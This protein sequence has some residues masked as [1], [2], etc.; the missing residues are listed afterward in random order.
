LADISGPELRLSIDLTKVPE[1]NSW[2]V[3][4]VDSDGHS[5]RP[6]PAVGNAQPNSTQRTGSVD[7]RTH[8]V[9]AS[10]S[11]QVSI[12]GLHVA[13][14]Y[15]RLWPRVLDWWMFGAIGL[16]VICAFAVMVEV[17][18]L[19]TLRIEARYR[20]LLGTSLFSVSLCLMSYAI[21]WGA[22]NKF[23]LFFEGDHLLE[24]I[25]VPIGLFTLSFLAEIGSWAAV[26]VA[27]AT[28]AAFFFGLNV[29]MSLTPLAW[30]P[31]M[32]GIVVVWTVMLRRFPDHHLSRWPAIGLIV[33]GL[34][35]VPVFL[36]GMT[37]RFECLLVERYLFEREART[38]R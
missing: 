30:F 35:A 8:R 29:N 34:A 19:S 27:A 4:F 20:N 11:C 3:E 28:I 1:P 26:I 37:L 21:L 31:L 2:P 38:R 7:I 10:P 12:S 18:T 32:G 25:S 17:A 33:W 6:A 36:S 14:A 9:E 13:V 23:D 16:A 5:Y 15:A 22:R 24:I